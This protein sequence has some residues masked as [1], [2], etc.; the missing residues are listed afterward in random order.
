MLTCS[1]ANMKNVHGVRGS[2]AEAR[3]RNTRRVLGVRSPT[4]LFFKVLLNS[5]LTF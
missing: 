5:V 1:G 2:T 4:S 3:V